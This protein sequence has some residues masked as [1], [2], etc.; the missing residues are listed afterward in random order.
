MG[1]L[2]DALCVEEKLL[3][4]NSPHV[5]C[6]VNL[7]N[8]TNLHENIDHKFRFIAAINQARTEDISCSLVINVASG[9]NLLLRS[10]RLLFVL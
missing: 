3:L 5:H 9:S 4:H 1:T 10:L 8:S 7:L 6:L 2:E